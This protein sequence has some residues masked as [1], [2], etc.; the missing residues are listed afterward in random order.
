MLDTP[1]ASGGVMLL[2]RGAVPR[3]V[4][5]VLELE[6]GTL[7][8]G[9]APAFVAKVMPNGAL[10][11]T[12]AAGGMDETRRGIDTFQDVQRLARLPGGRVLVVETHRTPCPHP[13]FCGSDYP[14]VFARRVDAGGNADSTYGT[15]GAATLR[16]VGGAISISEVGRVTSFAIQQFPVGSRF[17][18][19]ALDPNGISDAPFAARAQAAVESCGARGNEATS[20]ERVRAVAIGDR[21]VAATRWYPLWDLCVVRLNP[22]GSLDP[23]YGDGGRVIVRDE[24]GSSHPF[25]FQIFADGDG[26]AIL[27]SDGPFGPA[28]RM[29]FLSERGTVRELRESP[30]VAPY[31]ADAVVQKNGKILTAG[32]AALPSDRAADFGD[33]RVWRASAN[34]AMFDPVFGAAGNGYLPLRSDSVTVRPQRIVVARDG[35]ILVGG[36]SAA[37]GEAALMRI[38]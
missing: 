17:V 19:G 2:P 13:V 16:A 30:A 34:A 12:F 7:L 21:I 37:T 8:L 4:N 29:L 22:D 9:G 24:P 1:F 5:D 20:L 25:G 10:D 15:G 18:V 28:P 6:D 33:P 23:T 31:P 26:T 3:T 36:Q 32:F 35:A 11:T 27:L 38:R 14:A